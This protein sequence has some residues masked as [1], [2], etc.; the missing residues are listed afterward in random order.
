MPRRRSACSAARAV[1]TS[2]RGLSDVD[3]L[4]AKHEAELERQRAEQRAAV[5]KAR[6]EDIKSQMNAE[7]ELSLIHI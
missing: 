1:L 6:S 2:R 7:Q 3:E 4:R 5:E